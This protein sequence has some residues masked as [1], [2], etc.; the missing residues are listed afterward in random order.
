MVTTWRDIWFILLPKGVSGTNKACQIIFG[1]AKIQPPWQ[2][3]VTK[4]VWKVQLSEVEGK[5]FARLNKIIG[6]TLWTEV[7]SEPC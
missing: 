1:V 3:E 6:N 2:Q 7:S 4:K 5:C